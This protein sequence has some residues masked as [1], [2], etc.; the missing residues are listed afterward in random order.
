MT[1]GAVIV[2]WNSAGHIGACLDALRRHEPSM[3]VAVVD[4]ASADNTCTAVSGRG[5]IRLAANRENRGFAAAVNQGIRMLPECDLILV[6]NPDA[7]IQTS[8][9]AMRAEFA[10]PHTGACGGRLLDE[11]GRPQTGFEIRAFPTPASL[12]F[13]TLGLNRIWPSNPVNRRYRCL[14]AD[15]S[16]PCDAQQPAGAFLMIR[17]DA[18]RETGGFE[19]AF[20]PVWFEDVDFLR[21]LASAGWSI[22]FTPLAQAVHAGGH[23]V[24]RMPEGGREVAW[25]GSLLRYVVRHFSGAGKAAVCWAVFASAVPRA[26]V[27]AVRGPSFR[28]FS[29]CAKVMRL[30]VAATVSGRVAGPEGTYREQALPSSVHECAKLVNSGDR[31]PH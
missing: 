13:E 23:S 15:T 1:A 27:K 16:A 29:V 11:S 7:V 5:G 26:A 4:N 30:S 2:T 6:L 19:E 24:S 22:R 31:S 17:R 21:R 12:A 9:D 25:Y 10:S 28:P 18:W 20:H 14:D 8:L 3:A